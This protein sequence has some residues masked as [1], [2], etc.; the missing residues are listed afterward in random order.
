VAAA[1]GLERR[2]PLSRCLEC[3][4]ALAAAPRET[5]RARVPPY[6]FATQREFWECRACGRVFWAGSHAA[7]ILRR[8]APYLGD[9]TPPGS[10]PR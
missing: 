2:V 5:V 10:G 1:C 8:L 6:T 9:T 7:G 3:N 4:G